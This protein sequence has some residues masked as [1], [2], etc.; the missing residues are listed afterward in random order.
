[1]AARLARRTYCEGA[2]HFVCSDLEEFRED[3]IVPSRLPEIKSGKEF[4][5]L[6]LG[7]DDFY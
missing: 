5:D 7:G 3:A 1:M 2:R 4:Y 6:L